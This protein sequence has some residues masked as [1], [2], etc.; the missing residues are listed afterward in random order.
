MKGFLLAAFMVIG[1]IAKGQTT[2]QI[3]SGTSVPNTTL[4]APIYMYSSSTAF[5]SARSNILYEASEMAAANIPSGAVISSIAF[6]KVGTGATLAN[7]LMFSVYMANSAATAPLPTTSWSS[8]QTSHTQVYSNTAGFQVTSSPGWV[9]IPLDNP[10]T[11]TGGSLEIAF[12]SEFTGSS[13][14]STGKFDWQYTPGFAGYAVGD[15][16]SS[17]PASLGSDANYG[18]R[19]NIQITFTGGSSCTP[20]GLSA[21]STGCDSITINWT[22]Q[23][24]GAVIEYGPG[25]LSPGAGTFVTATSWPY[26]ITG[27]TPGTDYDI[28]VADTCD[29]DTSS[30]ISITETTATG[31]LP[32]ASFIIDSAVVSNGNVYEV[33]VDASSSSNA[34]SYS[35]N[36]GNGMGS[37]VQD[38]GSYSQADNGIQSITLVVSNACGSDSITI[39]TLVNI[40]L[41][42]NLLERSLRVYPN[43]AQ[44]EVNVSFNSDGHEAILRLTDMQGSEVSRIKEE[45]L[46]GEFTRQLDVSKLASGVYMLEI[47]AGKTKV[48]RTLHIR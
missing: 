14:Y 6:Y 34:D 36:Y 9:V 11:Y 1:I 3:G 37:G 44:Q 15:Q 16:G 32:T 41:D 10:F 27:L 12:E 48:L 20:T 42:E 26:T 19:P 24:G 38:T 18:E 46:E 21:S 43:P 39:N 2:V 33:Y 23:S 30:F 31:P 25:P 17:F 45:N 29:N 22:S 28:R 13:P 5:P 8:I 4:F 35:W 47:E 7:N 40:S